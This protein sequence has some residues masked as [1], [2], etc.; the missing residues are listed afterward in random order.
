MDKT[1]SNMHRKL[2]NVLMFFGVL[3]LFS[4]MALLLWNHWQSELAGQS[5]DE[6]LDEIKDEIPGAEGDSGD[7]EAV[8]ELDGK[9][10]IGYISIPSLNL[11]LPVFQEW[12]YA[13]LQIAP[14]RYSGTV[15][16]ENLVIA[17]HNYER[18][19]G[20]IKKLTTG[21][22][23]YFTDVNGSTSVYEVAGSEALSPYAV[24]DM[25]DSG[26]DLTMFTCTYDGTARIAVYC[27]LKGN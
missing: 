6:V 20:K 27:N 19:F 5:A 16:E 17:G 2:G 21:D 22:Q 10:Y 11:E 8:I 4:A 18:H 24:E 7:D 9:T 14:C 3:L 25:T 23:V 13:N 12:S 1:K 15:D 26:Y